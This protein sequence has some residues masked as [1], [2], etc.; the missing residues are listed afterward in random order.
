MLIGTGHE[1]MVPAGQ[2]Q[3]AY[4]LT[5]GPRYERRAENTQIAPNSKPKKVTKTITDYQQRPVP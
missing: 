2:H 5:S 3:Q 1:G 4:R